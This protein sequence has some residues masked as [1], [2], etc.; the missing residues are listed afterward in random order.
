MFLVIG[1]L[2]QVDGG[3]W[4][5]NYFFYFG[6][7]AVW[8]GTSTPAACDDRHHLAGIS[9]VLS[10]IFVSLVIFT[11]QHVQVLK[12]LVFI[13]SCELLSTVDPFIFAA[14]PHFTYDPQVR[15]CQGP[16]QPLFPFG[17]P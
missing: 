14:F 4:G 16:V 11:D 8:R 1:V 7:G 6:R 13:T 2:A 9:S 15:P 3:W 10:I 17:V 5:S 12:E